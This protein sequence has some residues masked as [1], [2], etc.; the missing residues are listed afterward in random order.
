MEALAEFALT[1]PCLLHHAL[2]IR[3]F[4]AVASQSISFPLPVAL[5]CLALP[6][7]SGSSTLSGQSPPFNLPKL[8]QSRHGR[9]DNP[10]VRMIISPCLLPL[11][12]LIHSFS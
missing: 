9:P 7:L 11:S 2:I 3:S 5:F 1:F 6:G 12:P 4:K 8:T 10:S